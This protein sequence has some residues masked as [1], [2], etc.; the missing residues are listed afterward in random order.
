MTKKAE[1]AG[2]SIGQNV[3]KRILSVLL[4]VVGGFLIELI[5]M[6]SARKPINQMKLPYGF[7]IFAPYMPDG[8]G[9]PNKQIFQTHRVAKRDT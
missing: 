5:E 8:L 9:V 4:H 1:T 6:V 7:F 2:S 3:P